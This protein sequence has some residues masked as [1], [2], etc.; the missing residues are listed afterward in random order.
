MPQVWKWTQAK[1]DVLMDVFLGKESQAKIAENHQ[2]TYHTLRTWLRNDEFQQE[3]QKLRDTL[4][5]SL[6]TEDVRYVTKEHRITALAQMAAS[7]REQYEAHPWLQEKRQIGFKA[8]DKGEYEPMYLI[9]ESYN[10]SAHSAFRDAIGDIA[11]ELGHRQTK[12]EHQ[13]TFDVNERVSFYIPE[14]ESP[15]EEATNATSS[16]E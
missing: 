1:R 15:P 12:V 6:F 14:P 5:L 13:G 9:N 16:H 10:E 8:N 4:E 3:L 11:K 2:I 7:A